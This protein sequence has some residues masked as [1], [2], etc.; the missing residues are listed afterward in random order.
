MCLGVCVS[1]LLKGRVLPMFKR[2]ICG[3]FVILMLVASVPF[4]TVS[5]ASSYATAEEMAAKSR[6]L[7]FSGTLMDINYRRYD[8]PSYDSKDDTVKSIL[9]VYFHDS[10]G[11]GSDNLAQLKEGSLLSYLMSSATEAKMKDYRYVVIA[12]QCPEGQ[13]WT[14]ATGKDYTFNSAS[15]TIMAAVKELVGEMDATNIL[16]SD[17]VVVMGSGD[18]ATAAYDYITRY[19]TNVSRM[20]SV[21]GFCDPQALATKERLQDKALRII[22]PRGDQ[23]AV[24]NAKALKAQYEEAGIN[25]YFE[26][27]EYEGSLANAVS[28][29][30]KFEEPSVADWAVSENYGSQKFHVSCHADKGGSVTPTSTQIGYNGSVSVL[31]R[32]GDGYALSGATI[33]GEPVDLSQIKKTGATMYSYTIKGIKKDTNL[34]VNFVPVATDTI[35]YNTVVS[36]IIKWSGILAGVFA[37]L[38]A[39][40]FGASFIIGKPL[41]KK[42]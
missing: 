6:A 37:L 1:V 4:V 24:V 38:A 9:I 23:Y 13:S 2:L 25:G 41:A 33:N 19:P 26:H 31:I 39:A 7:T 18:G 40:V 21:G 14:G 12:P 35:K 11:K 15:T 28:E 32:Q 10:D 22:A 34:Y 30:V 16:F 8:S 29:A 36:R 3:L 42:K 17:R 20:L 5:A 27:Y